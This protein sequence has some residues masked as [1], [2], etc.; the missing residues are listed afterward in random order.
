MKEHNA[1]PQEIQ[2]ELL[3]KQYGVYCIMHFAILFLSHNA[4][5]KGEDID[6]VVKIVDG[7]IVVLVLWLS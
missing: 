2:Y 7:E 5:I 1:I 4:A 6:K 3:E